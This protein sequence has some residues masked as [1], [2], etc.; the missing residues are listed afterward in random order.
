MALPRMRVFLPRIWAVTLETGLT[1][2]R[3]SAPW[4]FL[5]RSIFG[6]EP[7][8]LKVFSSLQ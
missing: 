4:P 2:G 1:P 6:P 8:E 3:A 7:E 5:P